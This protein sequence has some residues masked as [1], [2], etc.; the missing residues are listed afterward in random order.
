MQ[1]KFLIYLIEPFVAD[2]IKICVFHA[3]RS[4][5]LLLVYMNLNSWEETLQRIVRLYQ[6]FLP[7]SYVM[8][9]KHFA[10]MNESKIQTS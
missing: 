8:S 5:D 4:T 9:T 10:Y 7:C 6:D 3:L 2:I 1:S